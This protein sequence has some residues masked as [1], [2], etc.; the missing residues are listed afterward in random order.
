MTPPMVRPFTKYL[1][2]KGYSTMMGTEEVMITADLRAMETVSRS[3]AVLPE[4]T[5]KVPLTRLR[6]IIMTGY[7][8]LFR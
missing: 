7:C 3:D 1:E 6:R 2:R 8:S 5:C 4:S